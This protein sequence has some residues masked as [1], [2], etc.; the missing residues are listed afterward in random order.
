MPKRYFV[1]DQNKLRAHRAPEVVCLLET[2]PE[3]HFVLPDVAF[4]E[5]TK[6]PE[7]RAATLN[8]S[9]KM[10]APYRHRVH[11]ARAIGESL[12]VELDQK[13]SITSQM[14]FREGTVFG[15]SILQSL[16]ENINGMELSKI[17]NDPDDHHSDLAQD[18]FNHSLNKDRVAGLIDDMKSALSD[19]YQKDLRANRISRDD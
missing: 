16:K 14:M 3:T 5:M 12:L 9:L 1:L 17:R 15:R 8:A 11:I 10:L 7:Q 13:R 18:Y 6:N 2:S 19:R 4:V